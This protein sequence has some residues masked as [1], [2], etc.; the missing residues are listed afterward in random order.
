MRVFR[1]DEQQREKLVP[2][3]ADHR[4]DEPAGLSLGMVESPQRRFRFV[5]LDHCSFRNDLP[6]LNLRV[7]IIRP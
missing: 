6:F 7:A 5:R 2:R 1:S 4:L 3:A